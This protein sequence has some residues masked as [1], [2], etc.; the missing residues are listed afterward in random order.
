MCTNAAHFE[1]PMQSVLQSAKVPFVVVSAAPVMNPG[2]PES[3]VQ[4][5]PTMVVAAH[6]GTHSQHAVLLGE[7]AASLVESYT[8]PAPQ[9][10]GLPFGVVAAHVGT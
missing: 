1:S 5:S 3:I 8:K 7:V 9:T 2:T 6:V 10:C 4:A